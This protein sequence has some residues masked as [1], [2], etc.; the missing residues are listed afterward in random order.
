MKRFL[1]RLFG[2]LGYKISKINP[3]KGLDDSNDPF[4]IQQSLFS[5][6]K[7]RCIFDV[8]AHYGE[9]ALTYTDLFPEAN[10]YSFEPFPDAVKKYKENTSRYPKV[11]VFEKAFSNIEQ[12]SIFYINTSDATN[13]LL[14]SN[15]TDSWIDGATETKHSIKVQTDTIDNF[16]EM[17]NIESIDILKLD[18]QGAEL[19]VLEGA[20]RMLESK[21]INVIY[22]EV[23]F[24]EIYKGQPLFHEITAFL[25]TYNYQLFGLHTAHKFDNG[26]LAWGDA[27]YIKK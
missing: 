13:S 18:V 12:E 11:K 17:M 22:T 14:N 24:I 3:Q 25:S 2:S 5:N 27:I 23:E 15:K 9:T 26:Q 20:A 1:N 6:K 7:P 19:L 10:I 21:K 4:K 16:C 8:G